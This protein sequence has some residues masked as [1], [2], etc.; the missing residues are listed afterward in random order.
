[1]FIAFEINSPQGNFLRQYPE[2]TDIQTKTT[3]FVQ[4]VE[5]EEWY[6]VK[7]HDC[8]HDEG[9]P[10]QPW[11]IVAEKGELPFGEG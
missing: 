8:Y 2:G 11:V 10:C 7:H 3:E 9:K 6:Q 5:N 1:M 4:E